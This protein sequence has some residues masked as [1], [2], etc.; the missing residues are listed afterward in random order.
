MEDFNE[1]ELFD[2]YLHNQLSNKEKT[3]FDNHLVNDSEFKAAFDLHQVMMQS[4]LS[5]GNTSLKSDLETIHHNREKQTKKRIGF[6]LF[7]SSLAIVGFWLAT[8]PI[9]Q[10]SSIEPSLYC[11]IDSTQSNIVSRSVVQPLVDSVLVDTSASEKKEPTVKTEI[12]TVEEPVIKFELTEVG[13]KMI[14]TAEFTKQAQYMYFK[15]TLHLVGWEGLSPNQIDLRVR[16]NKLY[17]FFK[18]AYYEL[19]ETNSWTVAEKVKDTRNFGTLQASS[20][21]TSEIGVLIHPMKIERS[22]KRLHLFTTD[23]LPNSRWYKLNNDQFVLSVK[24]NKGVKKGKLVTYKNEI[25]LRT[26]SKIFKLNRGGVGQKFKPVVIEDWKGK[27]IIELYI[28]PNY[29][30]FEDEHNLQQTN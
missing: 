29:M 1:I 22:S 7:L 21:Q 3:D 25:Y 5:I 14:Y 20:S 27:R 13:P 23:S 6:Y 30:N 16:K 11:M 28:R 10:P 26:S 15:N 4:I 8:L 2:N 18:Q 19:T 9:K 12:V 24:G 17:I